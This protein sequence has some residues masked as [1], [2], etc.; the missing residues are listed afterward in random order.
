M[1]H[2]YIHTYIQGAT[3]V[4]LWLEPVFSTHAHTHSRDTPGDT[5]ESAPARTRVREVPAAARG[6]VAV[7]AG[8]GASVVGVGFGSSR[9][10]YRLES[11]YRLE[12]P[13]SGKLNLCMRYIQAEVN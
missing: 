13:I 1:R 7:V 5:P 8:V 10:I 11:R 12:S 6:S 9:A 4:G 2:T 3:G